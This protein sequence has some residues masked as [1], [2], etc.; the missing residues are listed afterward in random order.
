M[1]RAAHGDHFL[2]IQA[3]GI[4]KLLQHHGDALGAPARR[5]LP[6]VMLAQA[7]PAALRFVEA[8]GA[9]QQAG[10][11]AAV[12]ADQ[13]DEFAGTDL[14]L[15]VAQLELVVAV[16]VAQGRPVQVADTQGAHQGPAGLR[17]M[18]PKTG[19][20]RKRALML[21]DLSG[22]AVVH[23]DQPTTPAASSH[24]PAGMPHPGSA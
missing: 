6:Q 3:E 19:P 14:Q 15:N 18:T 2:D 7:H 1:G 12:G 21:A 4:G 24:P 10:F 5:L 17:A 23:N 20:Y 22:P 11:A 8:V 9:A 16:A 13:T